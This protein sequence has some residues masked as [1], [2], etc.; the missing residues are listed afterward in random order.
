[1]PRE[2][3]Q[4]QVTREAGCI[5]KITI[6]FGSSIGLA[7]QR[8]SNQN[9]RWEREAPTLMFSFIAAS[10]KVDMMIRLGKALAA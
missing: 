5:G 2:I 9:P 10:P 1:M 7:K 4:S 6:V 8:D 3:L